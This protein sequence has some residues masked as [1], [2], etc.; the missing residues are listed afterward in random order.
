MG[1]SARSTRTMGSVSGIKD[2][3]DALFEEG[4][5]VMGPYRAGSNAC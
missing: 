5:G 3:P 4:G 2:E 1:D